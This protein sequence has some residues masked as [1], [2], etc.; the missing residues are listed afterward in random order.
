MKIKQRK[1]KINK[2]IGKKRSVFVFLLS[3]M[4][5]NKR[6]EIYRYDAPWMVY[7][8]NW[9][10]RPDKRFRLAL[11]SFIEEYN[12]K[13][14]ERFRLNYSKNIFCFVKVQIITL[15][16]DRSEFRL[17]SVFDHPYPTTKV[18]WI[19]DTVNE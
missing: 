3:D 6:K 7:A 15:D 5:A 10:I 11:G 9:S 1:N 2:N 16:E 18:M 14:S 4:L 19:P 12:N 17:C 8:M 13:V